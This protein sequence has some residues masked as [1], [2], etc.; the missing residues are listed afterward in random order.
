MTEIV[1]ASTDVVAERD[2]LRRE[3]SRLRRELMIADAN[4]E[5][6]RRAVAHLKLALARP[7]ECQVCETRRRRGWRARL[8]RAWFQVSGR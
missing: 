4:M 7:V 3:V 8:R 2:E 5:A 1:T 6:H